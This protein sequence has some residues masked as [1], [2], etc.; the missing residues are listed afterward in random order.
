MANDEKESERKATQRWPGMP[1]RGN[2]AAEFLLPVLPAIIVMA[3]LL[4]L[5]AANA[6]KRMLAH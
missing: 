1:T 3:G 6:V 5:G 4:L 2:Q